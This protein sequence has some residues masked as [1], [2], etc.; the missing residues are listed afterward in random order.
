MDVDDGVVVVCRI[1]PQARGQG[2]GVGGGED[3]DEEG[4]FLFKVGTGTGGE[5]DDDRCGK[6]YI[7][8]NALGGDSAAIDCPKTIPSYR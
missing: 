1:R 3:E 8:A 4:Y 2:R 5:N 6:V 7:Y